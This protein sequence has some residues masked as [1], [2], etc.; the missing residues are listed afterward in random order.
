MEAEIEFQ[1][2]K[3][4][5]LG[6]MRHDVDL[7]IEPNI[8]IEGDGD[9]WHANPNDYMDR[10]TLMRGIKSDQIISSSSTIIK[11]AKWVRENDKKI[12]IQLL[13]QTKCAHGKNK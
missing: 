2:Q 10:G 5:N 8:C 12:T 7:F 6:F 11:T 4:F 1:A 3:N 13:Q 9:F